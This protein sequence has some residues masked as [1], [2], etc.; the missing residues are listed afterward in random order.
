MKLQSIFVFFI[1]LGAIS[2]A[3][4]PHPLPDMDYKVMN[5]LDPVLSAT[6]IKYV[7]MAVNTPNAHARFG[8][9][10]DVS[11]EEA[12]ELFD[13][14]F[15]VFIPM[16]EGQIGGILTHYSLG[17]NKGILNPTQGSSSDE[18]NFY[19]GSSVANFLTQSI[20]T[21]ISFVNNLGIDG[22]KY[23]SY[24]STS[25]DSVGGININFGLVTSNVSTLQRSPDGDSGFLNCNAPVGSYH[26][27][28]TA[29]P[30]LLG[31]LNS[32]TCNPN[33]RAR[34]KPGAFNV[35][36]D[37]R[38]LG[39]IVPC[40][41]MILV[42]AGPVQTQNINYGTYTSFYT[43]HFRTQFWY[44]DLPVTFSQFQATSL[45]QGQIHFFGS[46]MAVFAVN[47]SY[48]PWIINYY[49]P[50]G[51]SNLLVDSEISGPTSNPVI[52]YFHKID[53]YWQQIKW[54]AIPDRDCWQYN[55]PSAGVTPQINP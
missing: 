10:P 9:F 48:F 44:E 21:V 12:L 1:V 15:A 13:N 26:P 31:M 14:V 8:E 46:S 34:S 49:D 20:D 45:N 47:Q 6:F 43:G 42:Y 7:G 2:C 40:V 3:K 53:Y 41:E 22:Y 39:Q 19:E 11:Q 30:Q 33:L 28:T 17:L 38:E 4:N 18:M 32:E 25:T 5:K 51:Y 29:R 23:I 50:I 54:V 27:A 55:L 24:V 35:P 16:R 37:P 36:P 52:R